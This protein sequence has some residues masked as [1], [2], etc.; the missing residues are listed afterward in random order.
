MMSPTAL[1]GNMSSS[2]FLLTI[3]SVRSW[4]Q[5]TQQGGSLGGAKV[6]KCD[7][8][9]PRPIKQPPKNTPATFLKWHCSDFQVL[10]LLSCCI[11]EIFVIE[12]SN[13]QKIIMSVSVCLSQTRFPGLSLGESFETSSVHPGIALIKTYHSCRH[14]HRCKLPHRSFCVSETSEQYERR[15]R[16]YGDF[17]LQLYE[18]IKSSSHF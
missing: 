13:L 9:R 16:Q 3:I 15:T 11:L 10:Y 18:I 14:H 7:R 17:S 6:T 4:N 1:R 5:K 12:C 8:L 2:S